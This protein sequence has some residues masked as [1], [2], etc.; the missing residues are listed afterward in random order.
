MTE[1]L[2][3]LRS[4]TVTRPTPEMRRAMA[5]AVV[6]D[7]VYG[8][9]PT[10]NALEQEAAQ[11]LGKEAALYVPSGTMGNQIAIL[12]HTARGDEVLVDEQ[13]HIYYYEVGAPAV[14]SAVQLR[15][16][17]G[18]CTEEGAQRLREALR[19]ANLHFPP[20]RLV[21]LENT[22]NRRGGMA[23]S[24]PVMQEI[25][26]VARVSGLAVH[27]DGARLFNAALA[28]GCQ[29]ADL[30]ACCDS[31]MFCVSKG[32]GA[33]VGSL[34]CGSREF[35][36]RARKY[37]KLLGGGMR[38]AG[39]LA[40]A[41]RVAL[42]DRQRLIEDHAHAR[43]LAEQL[44][45]MPGLALAQPRVDSNIVVV[46]VSGLGLSA[47]QFAARLAGRGVLVSVF[48]PALV[49]LVTHSDVS[50]PDIEKA[51]EVVQEVCTAGQT[52]I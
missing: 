28:L 22:H 39:V 11:L 24:L 21:C 30:A 37:R 31:V 36:T 2:I 27:L 46:D 12:T 16:V 50:R 42:A 41:A 3:D 47:D 20:T 40:A 26:R 17:N 19:P 5:E 18:L 6:G 4:D 23:L 7:D 9:D 25:S 43:Y 44:A 45:D 1:K 32:L 49:R 15:P 13:A 34:L 8:E 33:P 29:A 51:L 10:V 14:L 52:G 48:G 35:I 38:Q